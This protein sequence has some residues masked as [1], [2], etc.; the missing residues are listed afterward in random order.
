MR[1]LFRFSG[2]HHRLP[3]AELEGVLRGL[4]LRWRVVGREVSRNLLLI[5]VNSNSIDFVRRLALTHNVIEVVILDKRLGEIA[6]AVYT[7]IKNAKSF[8]V[9]SESNT[10]EKDLGALLHHK[11][12]KVNLTRPE[13]VVSAC[14]F[15]K[16]IAVGFE[17]PMEKN[18]D[19][20]HP[21]KRPF[22]HP[23]S[24]KP[25]FAR[26]LL[27]LACLRAGDSVLDP[28]CGVGGILIEA[29]LMG[30][31]AYGLDVDKSMIYGCRKN[32]S[33]FNVDAV[34]ER[35]DALGEISAKFDAIVTDPPYGKSSS[36]LGLSPGRLYNRFAANARKSLKKG[37]R[38][39]VVLP[40]SYKLKH[41]G[42]RLEDK[43]QV[44][45]HKSLTRVIWILRND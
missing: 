21:L 27:N 24:M 26:I 44:R 18:F 20:R 16:K 11:G 3:E 23:T 45:I 29:G 38:L 32:L 4:G 7:R 13:S 25:K 40:S 14:R 5:E 8:R 10:I 17:I 9:K 12:L 28:F 1:L 34:V 43:F 22:F 15:K 19:L 6:K 2:E 31:K 37:S 36:T 30:F 41:A 33:F 42:F 39:V 35:G